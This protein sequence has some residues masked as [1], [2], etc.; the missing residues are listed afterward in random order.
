MEDTRKGKTDINVKR[1]Y[2]N[3]QD[4]GGA[5]PRNARSEHLLV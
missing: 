1:K 2:Q 3:R 5:Q 4:H